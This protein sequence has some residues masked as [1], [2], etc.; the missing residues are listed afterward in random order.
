[1]VVTLRWVND[2]LDAHEEFIG[3]HSLPSTEARTIVSVI[4]DVLLCLNLSMSKV[5]GQC[6]DGASSMSG[7]RTGVAKQILD[8]EPR[9][10]YTHCYGHSLNLAASDT[11]QKC[12]LMKSALEITHEITKLVKYS[13]RKEYLFHQIKDEL[14]PE[15]P[16]I[17]VLC[18]T[19]WTVRA[20]SMKNIIENHS[21]LAELWDHA[22]SVVK[23]TDMIARI[24]GVAAQMTLLDFFYGLV[25][26]ELLLQHTDNLSRALQHSSISA[27]E[28]PVIA[29]MT[30]TTLRSL[31]AD[32][33]FNVFLG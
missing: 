28:G 32:D 11:L 9:A 20:E 6:C 3:L 22:C 29:T 31:R 12:K 15:C 23:D 30:V 26:G 33:S 17:R 16:G 4:Q 24:R 10:L 21:V 14:A 5:R 18:P 1:M 27:A 2:E 19:R 7:I 25:L 8:V 13:P